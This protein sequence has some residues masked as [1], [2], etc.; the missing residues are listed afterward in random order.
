MKKKDDSAMNSELSTVLNYMEK[1]RGIDR[2][3]LIRAIEEALQS[4]S[5]KVAA[6]GQTIRI[7]I[8]RNTCEIKALSTTTVVDGSSHGDNEISLAKARKI[9]PDAKPGDVIEIEVTPKNFGR[10]AAQT[11]KQAIIQK[12]RQAEK[13]IVFEEYKDRVGDIVSGSVR[14]FSR[15]D[16]IV[17]LGRAE[18]ILPAG[19]RVP[20]EEYQIGDRIRGYVLKVQN[21]PSGPGIVLSRSHPD[22]VKKL[23]HLEISEIPDGV[24]EILAIAREPGYR[25]KVTVKSNNDK[26][27]PV[28]ACVG[29][30][31]MRVKNIVREL[32]GEK[33]DII[34]WSDDIKTYATNALSPAKPAKITIDPDF[35][36]VLHV[37]VNADQLSLAIGKRGQNVRLSSRLLGWKIDIQKSEEDVSFEEKVSRAVDS[38]ALVPGIGHDRAQALVKAGF[39]T[40]E[41][42]LT[43]EVADL[44][45]TTGFDAPTCQAIYESAVARQSQAEAAEDKTAPA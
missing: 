22:F 24:V 38:L 20:T 5:R 36:K 43:A 37:V 1:D 6:S 44:Q 11:A 15:S 12:I 9:K 28:G 33:I 42:I 4:A 35:P 18:A 45:E 7:V 16:I 3:T 23:F 17:D 21:N 8:D 39:L 29:M 19:E 13:T 34:R 41:G 26:V 31:G 25:T 14:Q 32:S 2:E 27:D 10:I 30:R 40:V